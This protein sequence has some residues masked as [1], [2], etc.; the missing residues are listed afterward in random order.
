MNK[1]ERK[2]VKRLR[3]SKTNN[4]TIEEL[5]LPSEVPLFIKFVERK[6]LSGFLR[7][8]ELHFGRLSDYR[9]MALPGVY[10]NI[11]TTIGDLDEDVLRR[12]FG[13][14]S[15]LEIDKLKTKLTH[16]EYGTF[17]AVL[18]PN[19]AAF[20]FTA[21]PRRFLYSIGNN[22]FKID[23]GLI[24]RLL[25]SFPPDK[26]VPVVLT[27]IGY[28]WEMVKIKSRGVGS[29]RGPVLYIDDQNEAFDIVQNRMRKNIDLKDI[30]PFTKR[31]RYEE[32]YEYRFLVEESKV[33]DS[34][35]NLYIGSLKKHAHRVQSLNNIYVQVNVEITKKSQLDIYKMLKYHFL[36]DMALIEF[37][38]QCERGSYTIKIDVE[39]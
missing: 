17:R 24:N 10:S 5:G 9:G 36:Y 21:I 4:T 15:E 26:T 23:T 35:G 30:V 6:Y 2:L 18:H 29:A 16:G 13:E 20:C 19:A 38:T 8:G 25:Q 3:S 22:T 12:E 11:N 28:I 39:E 7:K 37:K 32:Q 33:L 1:R 14:N 34:N 31:R 27:G